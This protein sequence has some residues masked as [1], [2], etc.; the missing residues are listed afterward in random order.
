MTA[1]TLVSTLEN[2]MSRTPFK[3]FTVEL[4]GGSR[5]EFDHRLVVALWRE[6][7]AIFAS[8]GGVPV[9][10]DNESVVQIFDAPASDA[11]AP[12]NRG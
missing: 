2:L 4:H 12:A 9:Y 8:P 11:P 6:G 10:F 1:E 3:P 5:L 7:K